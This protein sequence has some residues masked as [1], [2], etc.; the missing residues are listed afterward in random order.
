MRK[1]IFRRWFVVFLLLLI[2]TAGV[3]FA[4]SPELESPHDYLNQTGQIKHE[5]A[6]EKEFKLNSDY[7][8]GYV[9]DTKHILTLPFRWEKSDWI[10]ASLIAG[11]TFGL[12]AYDDEIQDWVQENRSS[13][14]DGISEFAKLFGDGRFTL[15]LLGGTYLYGHFFEVQKARRIALLS[16]ESVVVSGVFVQAIKFAGHRHR[17]S[18]GDADDVWD[19]P[20]F[21][22]SHLSFPSGHSSSA[23]AIATVI[24]SE[25]KDKVFVPPLA[26]GIATLT[27]LSRINDNDHWASDVFF[28]SV[29][30]YCTAK[31]IV[32]L[33][34]NKINKN[35]TLFPIIDGEHTAISIAYNF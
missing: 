33:H 10:K 18:T 30:G 31:V 12:F 13:T 34:N 3:S 8:K 32:G 14:S 4:Q 28:G 24:A 22:T 29:I 15:P 26:Y 6:E 27:A 5:Q 17:P 9:T 19:G 25:Y 35:L 16:I 21:S 11:V 1:E 20:G 7:W 23:F 2:T